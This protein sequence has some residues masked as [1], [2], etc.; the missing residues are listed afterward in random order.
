MDVE[1]QCGSVAFRTTTTPSAV[2]FCHC[3][4]CQKQ[5]SSA[6]GISATFPV[7]ALPLDD[8]AFSDKLHTYT[9]STKSGGTLD[10]FFC[11]VCGARVYH[12]R[13]GSDGV[14]GPTL[15]IKG[16]LIKDLDLTGAKHIWTKE[17]VVPIP[18]DAVSWPQSPPTSPR[19]GT[20]TAP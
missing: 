1:C 11:K 17:A 5:S 7:N 15:N 8:P 12:R 16:G 18:K 6:F 2:Y 14:Q 10:C 13:R 4:E 3:T 9:R 20:T 19:L